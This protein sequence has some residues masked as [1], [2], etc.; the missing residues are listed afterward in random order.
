MGDG[1]YGT[2]S[3][4]AEPYSCLQVWVS[5]IKGSEPFCQAFSYRKMAQ[6]WFFDPE[7]LYNTIY[8]LSDYVYNTIYK[9]SDYVEY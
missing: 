5:L 7:S 3:H 4:I 6:I 8:K 1:D 9:L 2:Q